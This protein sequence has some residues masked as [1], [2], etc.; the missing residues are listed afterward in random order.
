MSDEKSI[1]GRSPAKSTSLYKEKD[2][3]PEGSKSSPQLARTLVKTPRRLD[4]K[5]ALSSPS[6]SAL[7]LPEISEDSSERSTSSNS[8][9]KTSTST[10]PKKGKSSSSSDDELTPKKKKGLG[11]TLADLF[12]SP[13]KTPKTPKKTPEQELME[14]IHAY[15]SAAAG[16]VEDT[17]Y[18]NKIRE[19]LDRG[20]KVA[21][22][23]EIFYEFSKDVRE[24]RADQP[25]AVEKPYLHKIYDKS[26]VYSDSELLSIKKQAR[27]F[28]ESAAQDTAILFKDDSNPTSRLGTSIQ[29]ALNA[30]T[31]GIKRGAGKEAIPH[32]TKL[33]PNNS[34]EEIE[35]IAKELANKYPRLKA[36]LGLQDKDMLIVNSYQ[37][38]R[39]A[40]EYLRSSV[41][42]TKEGIATDENGIQRSLVR[43]PD[44]LGEI[45]N[46]LKSIIKKHAGN[47]DT[48]KNP[49]LKKELTLKDAKVLTIQAEEFAAAKKK[50]PNAMQ[51]AVPGKTIS[52]TEGLNL[53]EQQ[54]KENNKALLDSVNKNLAAKRTEK[55]SSRREITRQSTG[56]G[57]ESILASKHGKQLINLLKYGQKEVQQGANPLP[58]SIKETTPFG[59]LNK[60]M[61]EQVK[62]LIDAKA[63]LSL[64]DKSGYSALHLC[65]LKCYPQITELLAERGADL[66]A[67]DQ[68]GKT[69]FDHARELASITTSKKAA[70]QKIENTLFDA[71]STLNIDMAEVVKNVAIPFEAISIKD[72]G[73]H[74]R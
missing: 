61:Y 53:I 13:P 55:I 69:A 60:S 35:L 26:S 34:A 8:P 32:L 30:E 27:E 63:D 67:P 48:D 39:G 54:I 41:T 11:S 14:A 15:R 57:Y 9:K 45:Q 65:V 38:L 23:Y 19:L 72:R 71:G 3:L 4:L 47:F 37:Y 5:S 73:E 31:F 70:Y 2:E 6:T 46:A 17:Y 18:T 25:G 21:Q 29:I 58:L 56:P 7:I 74:S 52:A 68:D 43:H 66:D 1:K 42:V 33:L 22:G 62:E 12:R 59:P 28:V 40:G 36:V 10:T 49:E 20:V 50:D 16:T 44:E 64:T 51:P 24:Q